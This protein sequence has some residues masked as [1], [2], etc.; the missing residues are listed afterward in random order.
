MKFRTRPS[1][2]SHAATWGR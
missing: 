2:G 1:S